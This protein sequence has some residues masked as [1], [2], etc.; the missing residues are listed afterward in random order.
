M[1]ERQTQI[2]KT[3]PESARERTRAITDHHGEDFWCPDGK[4]HMKNV[5]G[6]Y[7]YI[8]LT[9]LYNGVLKVVDKDTKQTSLF[10]NTEE[11][12]GA[13]WVID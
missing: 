7:G 13:G 2:R 3:W 9:D 5:A 11:L 10:N 8:D 1:S 12:L 6:P 4:L